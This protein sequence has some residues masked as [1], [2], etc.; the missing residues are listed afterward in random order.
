[1]KKGFL[2]SLLVFLLSAG[3]L[4]C[5]DTGYGPGYQT[6]MLTNPAFAGS[7]GDGTL[8]L[9]YLNFYPGRN[10]NLHSFFAS[11]DSFIPIIHGG[12]AV[13]IS[14]D[15]LGGLINDIRGGFSYSYHLQVQKNIFINAGLSASFFHR[16]FDMGRMIFP[17]QID[18]L[19]GVIY[20][21][22]EEM[23]I[24]GKT[25]FDVGAGFL[26]MAGK[27]T[28]GI[29]VNHLAT[30]DLSDN[31]ST[32]EKI[33]RELAI[34]MSGLFRIGND[35]KIGLRPVIYG[36][37]QGSKIIYGAGGVMETGFLALNAMMLSNKAGDVNIQT[38]I[39]LRSG[40]ISFFYNYTFNISSYNN[41]LPASLVH[42]AGIVVSLNNVDKRKIIK[43]I[44]FPKC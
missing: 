13:F 26:L 11:Y 1:M 10:Y 18:P 8:R 23:N 34:H 20:Q 32:G 6:I 22:S 15:Y 44:N 2:I 17:D 28:A 12:A 16:G 3:R 27:Y 43:T 40:V 35:H 29:A 21:S 9:S 4:E 36:D 30:P 42:Q 25:V 7:E 33:E 31:G 41:L 14:N 39:F 37:F 5:Q 24:K 38:G 19:G